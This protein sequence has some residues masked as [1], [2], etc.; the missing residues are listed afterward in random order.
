MAGDEYFLS[1]KLDVASLTLVRMSVI[2][3]KKHIICLI[4]NVSTSGKTIYYED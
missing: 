2:M 1:T 3:A 4:K